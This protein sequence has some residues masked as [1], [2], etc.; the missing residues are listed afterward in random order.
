MR[1]EETDHAKWHLAAYK[2]WKSVTNSQ[3]RELHVTIGYWRP[4][5]HVSCL[6]ARELELPL[7]QAR[8][9]N[10]V[11]IDTRE[12][13][14]ILE[15]VQRVAAWSDYRGSSLCRICK[16]HNGNKEYA[17]Q[18]SPAGVVYRWLQGLLHYHEKHNIASPPG[19][20]E[21]ME[22]A[23]HERRQPTT[24]LSRFQDR[25]GCPNLTD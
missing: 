21:F 25:G 1:Y 17:V 15:Q 13:F 7:P 24:F 4:A 12:A 3:P 11:D 19:L 9:L 8:D 16:A 5:A 2:F 10:T 23:L 6:N 22:A 14:E 18:F 20:Y